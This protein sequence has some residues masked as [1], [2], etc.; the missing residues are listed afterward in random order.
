[1]HRL[2]RRLAAGL[3]VS[4][5]NMSLDF[6]IRRWLR[7]LDRPP[8]LWNPIWLGPASAE[9]IR[10]LFHDPLPDEEL[11][12]EVLGA[13]RKGEEDGLDMVDQTLTFYT[14]FYLQD[15]IL[16]KSDRASMLSS[17]ELRTPFLDRDL[18]DFARR[19]PHH[20]KMRNGQR[21]Y[22]LKRSLERM[23]PKNILHRRKKG[24]GIP[25]AK[26]MRDMPLPAETGQAIGWKTDILRKWYGAHHVGDADFRQSLWCW[27]AVSHMV[28]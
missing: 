6:K 4:T 18:V 7:G 12:G 24:F 15:G 2:I 5:K 3:P 14:Q 25:L 20:Y 16:L 1:V 11:Y 23:L 28:G 8:S 10:D 19:L 22:L 26:W 27:N 13:W 21:K 17:L 9:E